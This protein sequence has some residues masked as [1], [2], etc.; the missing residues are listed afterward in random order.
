MSS[1]TDTCNSTHRDML[2]E[3]VAELESRVQ[4]H[5]TGHIRTTISVLKTRIKEINRFLDKDTC[6]KDQ[7]LLGLD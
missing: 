4:P 5:D 6:W 3:E 2:L 7:M 1:N